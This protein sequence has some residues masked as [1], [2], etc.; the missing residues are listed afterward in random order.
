MSTCNRL[1]LQTLGSQPIMPKN[2]PD[3]CFQ[4]PR[5]DWISRCGWSRERSQL[6]PATCWHRSFFLYYDIWT[7]SRGTHN[8]LLK[9]FCATS[10]E[11]DEV[12]LIFLHVRGQKSR[13]L[14]NCWV[15]LSIRLE[16]L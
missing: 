8:R 10:G 1:E 4:C 12:M 3:H 6:Q 9:R 11:V 13:G 5:V 2:L 16:V 14:P 15:I 7:R